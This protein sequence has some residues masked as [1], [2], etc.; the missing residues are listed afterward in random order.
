MTNLAI[1]YK[2]IDVLLRFSVLW[3]CIL[4]RLVLHFSFSI[5][6]LI[7][8]GMKIMFR[9][10]HLA[11][12]IAFTFSPM[13]AFAATVITSPPEL[14]N[15]AYIV[16]DYDSGQVLAAKNEHNKLPPASMTKMMTSYIIEQQLLTGKLTENEPVRVNETAWCRGRNTESCMFVPLHGTATVLEML[17]GIIVQSGNDASLAMAEYIAGSD[18]TFAHMMNQEAERLGMKN[19]RFVNST[20]MPADGHYSTAADM[21]LLSQHIIRDSA[22]YYP[23]YSEKEFTF[24]G[25]KQNNRNT[26]LFTDPSVDG[27]KTG[28]TNE[29]G[30]CLAASSKRGQMRLITVI[31]GSPSMQ[32]RTTQARQLLNWGFDNFES[33]S[34]RPA[35]EVITTTPV[36]F[37]DKNEAE[38]GL[39]QNF[40]IIVPRGESPKIDTKIEIQ[41]NL[42]APLKQGQVIGK[43]TA[44]KDDKVL[45][46]KP[47]VV[48]KT[49]EEAGFFSRMIDHIKLFFSKLF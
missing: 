17:R 16:I 22:K 4:C 35:N 10:L 25:I 29:A 9:P 36:W 48:L 38:V 1:F 26:L 23:L 37:G 31:L 18:G 21:A 24:N 43:I 5:L 14:D 19:T 27:L 6:V 46:E 12:I 20:G 11:C 8:Y 39:N 41:P 49:I 45:A 15:K 7:A 32:A 33:I 13:T 30:F 44:Y 47:L 3:V 42:N 2:K 28:H 40:S 34:I